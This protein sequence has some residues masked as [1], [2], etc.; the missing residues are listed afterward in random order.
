MRHREFYPRPDAHGQSICL[1]CFRSV[2]ATNRETLEQAEELHRQECPNEMQLSEKLRSLWA[3]PA[4]EQVQAEMTPAPPV[5]H[6][7][8]VWEKSKTRSRF[9]S[10]RAPGS[11]RQQRSPQKSDQ[12][13]ANSE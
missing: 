10:N 13:K 4:I 3:E 11:T 2:K 6:S 5:A 1:S 12:R 7:S 8:P 9:V